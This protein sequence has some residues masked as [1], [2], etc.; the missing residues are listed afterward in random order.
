M[1]TYTKGED[2]KERGDIYKTFGITLLD[3]E[4]K[5]HVNIIK[6]YDEQLRDRVLKS[7]INSNKIDWHRL[8]CE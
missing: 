1:K 5:D 3:K 4:T 8:K 2:F 6:V 7:L